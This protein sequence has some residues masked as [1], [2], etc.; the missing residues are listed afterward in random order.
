MKLLGMIAALAVSMNASAQTSTATTTAAPAAATSSTSA[1]IAQ[2]AAAKAW[3]LTLDIAA[4]RSM[5]ANSETEL[6]TFNYLGYTYKM[7]DAVKIGA[8]QYFAYNFAAD[9]NAQTNG[10]IADLM[11]FASIT[12]KDV[13]GGA[14][15]GH[16]FRFY[17]PVGQASQAV[18]SN[19][20]LRYIF[21]PSWDLGNNFSFD[22]ILDSNVYLIST[23][24]ATTRDYLAY[25]LAEVGYTVNDK[26]SLYQ[27]VGLVHNVHAKPALN[28]MAQN[29]YVGT[30]ANFKAA[31]N[32]SILA[33]VYQEHPIKTVAGERE[34]ALY[35]DTQTSA[36]LELTMSY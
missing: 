19:G 25:N 34:F 12:Q 27:D 14:T 2:P 9:E 17:I 10:Q 18:S 6:A 23:G 35:R 16:T 21:N 13:L 5:V 32:F 33:E 15:L 3:T 20:R 1:T 22:Y 4:N 31:K 7:N 24:N 11:P 28:E 8:R 29:L 26:L 30:G 36:L